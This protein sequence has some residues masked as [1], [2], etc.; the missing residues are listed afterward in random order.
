MK[1]AHE[2]ALSLVGRSGSLRRR[3]VRGGLGSFAVKLASTLSAFLLAVLLARA[4]GPEGYGI[5]TYAFALVSLLAIPAQL[6]LPTLVVR[7]TARAQAKEQWELMRGVWR[8]ATGVVALLSLGLALASAAAAWAFADSFTDMQLGTFWWGVIL[9]PVLALANLRGAALRGLRKV[10]LGQLP[11]LIIRPA[12][13][14]IL[15]LVA[16]PWLPPD[17]FSPMA[18]MKLHVLAAAFAFLVGAGLLWRSRPRALVRAVGSAYE[19]RKWLGSLVSLALLAGMQI[20]NKYTDILMLGIFGEA[21]EVGI[22]RIAMQAAILVAFGFQATS[23]VVA[24]YFTRLYEQGDVKRLQYLVTITTRIMLL[25]AVPI[26]V[27]FIIFGESILGLIF[28]SE[29][30][31]GYMALSILAIGKLLSSA[32]GPVAFL[33]NMTGNERS[34]AKAAAAGAGGNVLLNFI[35]IPLYGMNGAAIATAVTLVSWHVI[36]WWIARREL[37]IQTLPFPAFRR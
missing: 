10:V 16:L 18:A 6:G 30:V 9:V 23:M 20:F 35:L 37:G 8:W 26:V 34:T 28:G 2:R 14:I 24:P 21:E 36:L 22:Y 27:I 11:E 7:E 13:L 29:Y 4:L 31:A 15:I 19:P 5:Y 32:F 33:L 17:T 25:V 1:G 12:M 3:I